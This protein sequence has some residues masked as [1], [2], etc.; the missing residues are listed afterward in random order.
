[1]VNQLTYDQAVSL[2]GGSGVPLQ[3]I[4]SAYE[5]KD[6]GPE[7]FKTRV[8]KTKNIDLLW[9]ML[10][11]A[12]E[13]SQTSFL[14]RRIITLAEDKDT[15]E[16]VKNH[17]IGIELKEL[18]DRKLAS[19]YQDREDLIRL[20]RQSQDEGLRMELAE[21]LLSMHDDSNN[22]R[23]I[24]ALKAEFRNGPIADK[25]K[26][27][28][29]RQDKAII[30]RGLS[31]RS[32]SDLLSILSDGRFSRYEGDLVLNA[33]NYLREECR[34]ILE[35]SVSIQKL[36]FVFN[37]APEQIVRTAANNKILDIARKRILIY[38]KKRQ[39]NALWRLKEAVKFSASST[40]LQEEILWAVL[41]ATSNKV[42]V[43]RVIEQTQPWT[44]TSKRATH[45]LTRSY[46]KK[47]R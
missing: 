28:E 18:A 39:P 11:A 6:L 30:E 42:H 21:K 26:Q 24:N 10:P 7:R 41:L 17:A 19:L 36:K 15:L 29:E 27:V 34:K 31:S 35:K 9:S 45:I 23:I 12:R 8:L 40:V 2:S 16:S 13:H 46:L 37:H 43:S 33:R 5:V 44:K 47:V 25:V 4:L 14:F 32:L 1:M 20:L 22:Y 3:R 38:V